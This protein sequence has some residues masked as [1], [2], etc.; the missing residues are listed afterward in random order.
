LTMFTIKQILKLLA[1]RYKERL[2]FT[3]R[4]SLLTKPASFGGMYFP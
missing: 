1:K 2:Y 3:S 4:Q